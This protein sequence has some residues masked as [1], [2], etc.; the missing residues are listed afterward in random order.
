MELRYEGKP[1]PN[2]I[3]RATIGYYDGHIDLERDRVPGRNPSQALDWVSWAVD[4]GR[5]ALFAQRG[6]LP[7]DEQ[8]AQ[9]IDEIMH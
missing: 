6:D 3:K 8:I 9:V 1:V 2:A 4:W 7:T 5:Q